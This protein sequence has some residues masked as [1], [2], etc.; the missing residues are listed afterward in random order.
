MK[1]NELYHVGSDIWRILDDSEDQV[2]IIDCKKRSMPR[3]IR[4][5]N[6]GGAIPAKQEELLGETDLTEEMFGVFHITKC[7]LFH[8]S[9]APCS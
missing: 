4:R 7:L 2:L 8:V 9:T 6:F 1:K 3:L 5:E